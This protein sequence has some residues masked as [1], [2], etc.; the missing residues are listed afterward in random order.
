MRTV[1]SESADRVGQ[2]ARGR[3]LEHVAGGASVER[4]P[5]I[6]WSGK[7]RQDDDARPAAL[8]AQPPRELQPRHLRHLDVGDHDV[9]A[10]GA[11]ELE[12]LASVAGGADPF[13]VALDLQ[14]RGKGPATI[15]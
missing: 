4:A 12:S 2:T 5:Q 15:D 9:R 14:Q 1:P 7:G 8:V 3:C 11:R 10:Q 13:D 6:A